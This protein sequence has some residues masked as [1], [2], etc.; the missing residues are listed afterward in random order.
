M[1][2][3]EM[4]FAHILGY[5]L[6]RQ[7]KANPF[8]ITNM[9]HSPLTYYQARL[10]AGELQPDP[11]Q[12]AVIAAL[13]GLA[14]RLQNYQPKQQG[15]LARVLGRVVQPPRGL[16]LYGSVG[17]GK[18]MLMDL[19]FDAAPVARKRRVHFHQFMLEVHDQLHQWRNDGKE[20]DN[21]LPRLAENI[22]AKNL[23]L[24]FDEFHVADIADAMILSRLF[25]ALFEAGLV[26]VATS[27]WPPQDLYKNGLQRERFLPFIDVMRAHMDVLQIAGSQDHR[28]AR[29]RARP[30]Y[31]TPLDDAASAFIEHAFADLTDDS[32]PQPDEL[33]VQGRHIIVPR[34]AKGVAWF[35]FA[36]LCGQPLGA[37]DYLAI[38]QCYHTVILD[39][40][41]RFTSEQRNETMRFV[42][43]IDALYENRTKLV[44]AA[45]AVPDE[46]CAE[47][48]HAFTFQRTASRLTE[49]QAADY[50]RS[51]HFSA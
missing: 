38:A 40:V 47:G 18:S 25:S 9:K 3:A 51:G 49:M 22:V 24:C 26:L 45:A 50:I 41:P 32:T 6:A 23:L 14:E 4:A 10:A 16:Y 29:L 5:R 36:E 19:F 42:T 48:Q 15:L 34:A 27:N 13:Q 12:E 7:V 37:A 11:A 35:T 46:L 17:R 33:M 39:G 8:T 21:L 31:F 30:T 20:T 2:A 28:L 1:V 44:V 43:L